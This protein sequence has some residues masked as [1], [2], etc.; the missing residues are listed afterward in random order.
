MEMYSS[1]SADNA[2][3]S[4]ADFVQSIHGEAWKRDEIQPLYKPINLV[5]LRRQ[6]EMHVVS[7]PRC[8]SDTI[9]EFSRQQSARRTWSPSVAASMSAPPRP[10][11]EG[12]RI[13]PPTAEKKYRLSSGG[14]SHASAD[15]IRR[16]PSVAVPVVVDDDSNKRNTISVVTT[17]VF[18]QKRSPDDVNA[19][20][21]QQFTPGTGCRRSFTTRDAEFQTP[22]GQFRLVTSSSGSTSPAVISPTSVS[23]GFPTI[24]QLFAKEIRSVKSKSA[25]VTDFPVFEEEQA[26]NSG[27][28]TGTADRLHATSGVTP[29]VLSFVPGPPHNGHQPMTSSQ[30]NCPASSRQQPSGCCDNDRT[31]SPQTHGGVGI[32]GCN[33]VTSPDMDQQPKTVMISNI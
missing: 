17:N 33:G 13:G 25:H 8:V 1:R 3:S 24:E 19:N 4:L 2:A 9:D 26:T 29:V 7:R 16:P 30:D 18:I 20:H 21:G 11:A 5:Q 28:G 27:P 10:A 15:I 6:Q 32:N 22:T 31:V 12:R 23:S 14:S